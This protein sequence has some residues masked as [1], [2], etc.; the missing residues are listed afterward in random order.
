MPFSFLWFLLIAVVL[1]LGG[2]LTA[3]ATSTKTAETSGKKIPPLAT[4]PYVD[5]ERFMGD[6]YVQGI[7]PW[8]VER[9][10]VGTM[11]IYHLRPDGRIDVTYAFHKGSLDAPRRE[12]RAVARVFNKETNAEW[13]VRFIW[14]FEAAFLVIDLDDAYQTT[15]I[16]HPSR[17]LLWIMSRQPVLDD[18]TYQAILDR[19]AAQHYDVS[20]VERV[21]QRAQRF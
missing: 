10:N 4:V 12:M 9:G 18:A 1:V 13:R 11:D 8:V 21:P 16:G 14:P 6:W 19:V 17:N 15:A 3:C 5:M 20:R 2:S 7:I